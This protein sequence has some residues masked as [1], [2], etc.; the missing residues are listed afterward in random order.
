[1]RQRA[2]LNGT[3]ELAPST[4][5]DVVPTKG[6]IAADVPGDVHVA[7]TEAGQL[8]S[9]LF[10][11]KNLLEAKWVETKHW[12]YRRTFELGG[13]ASEHVELVFEGLDIFAKIYLNGE[14]IGGSNNM[15][16]A[17]RFDVTDRIR[18]GTNEIHVQFLPTRAE[19]ETLHEQYPEYHAIFTPGRSLVR[20]AQCQFGWDWAPDALS[21]GIWKDVYIEQF[22]GNSIRDV[23]VETQIDGMLCFR[24]E[25]ASDAAGKT[26]DVELRDDGQ[27][28]TEDVPVNG[29][30]NFLNIKLDNPKLWWPNGLGEPHMYDY[31]MRL[32]EGEHVLDQHDGRFGIR[33]VE[34]EEKIVEKD[35]MGFRV[36]V[37][38]VPVF[39]KGANWVPVDCFPGRAKDETYEWLVKRAAEANF[40]ML[41]IWGGGIYEKDRFYEECN[42]RG[43]MVWQDFM[44]AC[45]QC[46]D[47][48]QW[49]LDNMMKEAAYQLKRLRKHPCVVVWCG[50]NES[51]SSHRYQPD[52]PGTTL[53]HYY[54][55]GVV[56]DL[57][58]STP[59]L[60]SSPHSKSDFGQ[61]QT[62][63]ET[64]WS[65]WPRTPDV[66]Y[67][68]FRERLKEIRTV[69]NGE[70][71]LQGPSPLESIRRFA[72]DD[73]IWP[74][75][76]VMDFH[77]VHH[78]AN[79][80]THP[81]FIISQLK[82][83][84]QIIGPCTDAESFVH[85]AMM[86]HAEMM[87]EELEFY[88]ARKFDNSGAM[89]WMYNECWP[90][91]N[92]AMVDYYGYLKPAYF[93]AKRAFAPLA[94]C[95]KR[96]YDDFTVHL[97]NGTLDPVSGTLTLSCMD[98]DGNCHWTETMDAGCPANASSQLTAVPPDRVADG[99][100]FLRAEWHV[101]DG[102]LVAHYFVPLWKDVP[103]E[104]PRL[105]W[106][107][108]SKNEPAPSGYRSAVKITSENYAR[109]V[110]IVV[111]GAGVRDITLSDNYFDLI[112]GESR[113]VGVV[114]GSEIPDI[115]V[116]SLVTRGDGTHDH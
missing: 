78:P 73:D 38:D 67:G 52:Q 93:M 109:F 9:D 19:L 111:P 114:T 3:W 71:C 29:H 51:S 12:W 41:R 61:I 25:L 87:R 20:K 57:T 116:R 99:A 48:Q 64:H 49:F 40:N 18:H 91:S 59:Y 68:T 65:T 50:G 8:P 88:R 11:R 36:R 2:Y 34:I 105:T 56:Q 53:A 27:A 32:R 97:M 103:F 47:D 44:T 7:L 102:A 5:G 4:D 28:V 33:K 10:Y 77:V 66:Q 108:L 85:N 30:N 101:A 6:W 81:R 46:P 39:C 104:E 112:P 42:R 95:I 31:V 1:M 75:N 96:V 58:C 17:F 37:N 14:E 35:R 21:L 115:E 16:R 23:F 76:D 90:C 69:F 107:I 24:V 74:P 60:Y 13:D 82:M 83:A 106:E 94:L 98:I 89:T 70:I 80:K 100:H 72:L 55:R 15:H 62:S 63:G 54:L 26:L 45:A 79:P 113:A 110:H 22:D 86:A 43:I 84:E 92:W